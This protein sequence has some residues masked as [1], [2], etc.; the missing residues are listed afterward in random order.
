[1]FDEIRDSYIADN[2]YLCLVKKSKNALER[3]K[4][5]ERKNV[6]SRQAK[7][8]AE[9]P[10]PNNFVQ[11][12][13]SSRVAQNRFFIARIGPIISETLSTS[14]GESSSTYAC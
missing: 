12:S 7:L 13:Y 2:D 5:L 3:Y 8:T 10:L 14:T 4:P 9:F 6:C 1:M 11:G